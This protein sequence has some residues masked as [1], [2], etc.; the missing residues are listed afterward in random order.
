[1]VQTCRT[2]GK[3][4]GKEQTFDLHLNALINQNEFELKGLKYDT[5]MNHSEDKLMQQ[6][7]SFCE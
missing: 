5:K 4:Q 2:R 6:L 7:Y 3:T 1:M